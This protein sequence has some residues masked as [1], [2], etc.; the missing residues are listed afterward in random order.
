M[1]KE[2]TIQEQILADEWFLAIPD[3]LYQ[4]CPCGGIDGKGCNKKMRFVIKDGDE[5]IDKHID[6]FIQNKQKGLI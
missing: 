4:P 1:I 6:Q 5:E 3:D 2:R